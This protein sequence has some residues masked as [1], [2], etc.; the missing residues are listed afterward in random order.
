MTLA[1]RAAW[2]RP[3]EDTRWLAVGAQATAAVQQQQPLQIRQE[4]IMH[5]RAHVVTH[6][7][8][9]RH[10]AA[11]YVQG[12]VRQDTARVV[13]QMREQL[14]AAVGRVVVVVRRAGR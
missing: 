2:Y 14:R 11:T 10:Q 13:A 9:L 8:V 4:H 5:V 6:T 7:A 1:A 3:A 12:H